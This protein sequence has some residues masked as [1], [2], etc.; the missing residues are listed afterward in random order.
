MLSC[1]VGMVS[2]TLI[3]NVLA[4]AG[5]GAA[6]LYE[7]WLRTW[8]PL[9]PPVLYGGTVGKDTKIH[10]CRDGNP[11]FT[12][13]W[14][15]GPQVKPYDGERHATVTAGLEFVGGIEPQ[16]Q[17]PPGTPRKIGAEEEEPATRRWEGVK[18]R[19]EPS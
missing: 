7:V 17:H 8:R 1:L 4:P 18:R 10:A 13:G 14:Q 5:V 16:S 11:A 15:Y 19:V 9:N 3:F 2:L 12:N 6:P